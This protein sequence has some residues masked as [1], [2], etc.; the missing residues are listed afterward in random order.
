MCRRLET[1]VL[2]SLLV[3]AVMFSPHP[4]LACSC[5]GTTD[6][7]AFVRSDVVFTGAVADHS[8]PIDGSDRTPDVAV[9]T[10]A[11]DRVLKGEASARQ[12]VASSFTGSSCGLEL[13][14]D[15]PFIVFARQTPSDFERLVEGAVYSDLCSG[16]RSTAAAPVPAMFGEGAAPSPDDGTERADRD[17]LAWSVVAVGLLGGGAVLMWVVPL[18]RRMTGESSSSRAWSRTLGYLGLSADDAPRRPHTLHRLLRGALLLLVV[19]IL[20]LLLDLRWLAFGA[21]AGI[22]AVAYDYFRDRRR[23]ERA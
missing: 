11:V 6:E 5:A 8:G 18:R 12:P 9:W 21:V 10:F 3:A 22:G 19:G 13:Q 15:G 20:G 1:L 17:W 4:A 2:V 23:V 16:T 14:G 7:E